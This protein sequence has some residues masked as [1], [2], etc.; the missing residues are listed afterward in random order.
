MRLK[1]LPPKVKVAV[2]VVGLE[3]NEGDFAGAQVRLT[4]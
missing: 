3:Q 4:L 1:W 2:H